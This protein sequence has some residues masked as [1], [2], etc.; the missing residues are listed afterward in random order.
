MQKYTITLEYVDSVWRASLY[1][2]D[3]LSLTIESRDI[4]ATMDSV[5]N[6]IQE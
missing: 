6:W 3:E 1:L 2:R 5:S 4:L